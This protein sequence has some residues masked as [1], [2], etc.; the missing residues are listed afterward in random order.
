MRTGKLEI[1]TIMLLY[2][3]QLVL[4]IQQFEDQQNDYLTTHISG[5]MSQSELRE[6]WEHQMLADPAT[7][8]LPAGIRQKELN[9]L[10]NMPKEA[11]GLRGGNP[12]VAAGPRNIGGRGRAL[13]YDLSNP[14]VLIAGTSSGGVFRSTDEGKS[15]KKVT[16]QD[17]NLSISSLAQNPEPGKQHIWY[18]G[19]GE[20][21]GGS[22]GGISGSAAYGGNGVYR[23]DDS[24]KTWTALP[25]LINS[26]PQL[27]DSTDLIWRLVVSGDPATRGVYFASQSAI[28]RSTNEGQSWTKVLG[29]P[30]ATGRSVDLAVAANGVLYATFDNNDLTV[31]GI[32]RS[33]DGV[34]WTN[35]TPSG[36]PGTYQRLIIAPDPSRPDVVYFLGNTPGSGQRG[37]NFQ[38]GS[39]D[40]SLYKYTYLSGTGAGAGGKWD[41]RSQNL[42]VG[43]N[44]FDD[45]ISQGS[46]CI[47]IAVSPHD[48]DVVII[49]GTNLYI[50]TDAF[51]SDQNTSY[52]GG[53]GETTDLPDFQTYPNHHPDLQKIIY[54]PSDSKT[55]LTFSDGGIHLTRDLYQSSVVWESLNNYLLA[56]QFYTLA[57]SPDS[58]S[59][60]MMGGTQD[61]GTLLSTNGDIHVDW[62]MPWSYDGAGCAFSNVEP[63]LY[64][65]KQLDGIVKVYVNSKGERIS[66]NRIDPVGGSGYLFINPLLLDPTDN[67][68]MYLPAGNR[69]WVN[70]DVTVF[71]TLKDPDPKTTNWRVGVGSGISGT[72]TAID[73][74]VSPAHVVYLGTSGKNI[75]RVEDANGMSPTL[76][77][78]TNN[79]NAAGY[80]ADVS[81]DPRDADK[82]IV[83]YSNYNTY[84]VFYTENG[85]QLW[86]NISGNLE[87]QT[88]PGVPPNLGHI[89]DGPSC[90]SAQIVPVEDGTLYLVGTSI[91]LFASLELDSMQTEWVQVSPDVIGNQVVV[92]IKH[93][94]SDGFTAI[95]TH[96]AGAFYTTLKTIGDLTGLEE[97]NVAEEAQLKVFPNPA[98]SHFEVSITGV[99]TTDG[100]FVL[101]D[102]NGRII[103]QIPTSEGP[104][105]R[106]KARFN[107]STLPSGL[108]LVTFFTPETKI[109][110]RIKVQ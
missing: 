41:N 74:S 31:R 26:S 13:A 104:E 55:C 44:R 4:G 65:S 47:D 81:V 108:Y 85:G 20:A 98:Q 39:E 61:N 71:D 12:W 34:T 15:W 92:D 102:L 5:G 24:A 52:A 106:Q 62:T 30:I 10:A 109:S 72:L 7:G 8:E 19:T 54:S 50:S 29:G 89:N 63:F 107:C 86:Q 14:K 51:K 100:Q 59:K 22:Q 25:A 33:A 93:R 105:T 66:W 88:P 94:M 32:F 103:E 9:H 60:W 79:I 43:P 90:R 73:A 58:G 83:V 42:P 2:L 110:K 21:R 91:G 27:V 46:Y 48:T 6:Q 28:Y 18:M 3:V 36:F 69:L 82:V 67:K 97:R 95:A 96:G 99:E 11:T 76:T 35:I 16:T 40:H 68:I 53:Y 45:Y 38:G 37:Y 78:V 23:S 80:V 101:S 70:D 57:I 84:S 56:T 49:G 77:N 1:F 64:A 17:Q 75:Y 87:G